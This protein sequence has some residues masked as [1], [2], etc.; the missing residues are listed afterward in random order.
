MASVKIWNDNK[1]VYRNTFRGDPI[2]IP[3]GGFIEAEEQDAVLILGKLPNLIPDA[4]GGYKPESYQMLRVEKPKVVAAMTS[5]A[6][7]LICNQCGEKSI[8]QVK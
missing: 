1:Y 8:D 7:D 6:A 2:V 3:A 4:D 5:S